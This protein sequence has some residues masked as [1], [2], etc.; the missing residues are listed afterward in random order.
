MKKVHLCYSQDVSIWELRFI[1]RNRLTVQY[2]TTLHIAGNIEGTTVI[3]TMT[4]VQKLLSDTK[5]LF[6]YKNP[7]PRRF[8]AKTYC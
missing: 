4:K 5:S 8:I 6:D 2:N 1:F 3:E 7:Q